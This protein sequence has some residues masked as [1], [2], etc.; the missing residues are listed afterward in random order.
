MKP[1]LLPSTLVLLVFAACLWNQSPRAQDAAAPQ[2][3]TT[4]VFTKDITVYVSD[5]E[6]DAQNVNVDQGGVVSQVR[7]G[8]L[9][10]PSKR[11]KQDPEAQARKIVNLM[12]KSIVDD[13]QK[14]GYKAQ[15]LPTGAAR[16]TTGVWLHGVFTEVDEGN[17]RRRALIGFGA[18]AANMELYVTLTD[19]ANPEK[20]LYNEA[21][22]QDSGKKI[23]AV[24]TMNPYVAAA[25]YVMEKNAPEKTVKKTASEIS[26]ETVKQLKAHAVAAPTK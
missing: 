11:E 23:G 15:H 12:S 17:Q 8:I 26:A 22:D 19:L 7:P 20:P 25:K 16:P 5:F 4:H 2:Q 3:P 13:L 21:K 1:A 24:I 18:G 9:E 10:R 6:L 14:A